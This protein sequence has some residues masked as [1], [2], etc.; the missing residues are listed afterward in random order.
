MDRGND[1]SSIWGAE[2]FFGPVGTLAVLLVAAA[3]GVVQGWLSNLFELAANQ[4][5]SIN[6]VHWAPSIVGPE[7]ARQVPVFHPQGLLQCLM[8]LYPNGVELTSADNS[9]DPLQ[10]QDRIELINPFAAAITN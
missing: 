9:I 5:P 10:K 8:P 1:L 7:D 6:L 4:H 3:D 2:F